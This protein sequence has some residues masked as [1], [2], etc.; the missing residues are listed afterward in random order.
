VGIDELRK[1]G[2]M[3]QAYKHARDDWN[4]WTDGARTATP[5]LMSAQTV[6]WSGGTSTGSSWTYSPITYWPRSDS[7]WDKVSFFAYTPSPSSYTTVTFSPAGAEDENPKLLYTMSYSYASQTDLIVDAEYNRTGYNNSEVKFE[8]D[9]VLSRIGFQAQ[10]LKS[11]APATVT[12]SSLR[13]YYGGLRISGTYTFNSGTDDG[14]DKDNKALNNWDV[15]GGQTTGS[16]NSLSTASIEVTTM[17]KNLS[18]YSNPHRYLM[19]IPQ[20]N[21]AANPAFVTVSY[22]ITYPPGSDYPNVSVV[23]KRVYLPEITWKPGI[24]YTYTLNIVAPKEIIFNVN[25]EIGWDSEEIVDIFHPT[26]N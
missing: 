11:Y 2:F 1:Q 23:T 25:E 3:V 20:K 18:E 15:T 6:T 16:G 4:A 19:L 8:F 17:P 21:A 24:A 10:T 22:T 7:D 26:K 9:H 14:S 13:F 5:N 12:M